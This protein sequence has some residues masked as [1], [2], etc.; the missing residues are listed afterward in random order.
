MQ[1]QYSQMLSGR[2]VQQPSMSGPSALT[3]GGDRGVRM[4]SGGST[5]GM[6]CG[7]NNGMPIS[8]PGFQGIGSPGMLNVVTSGTM[9]PVS[10]VGMS[11]PVN[12]HSNAVSGQ[13]NSLL[14]P[15]DHLQVQRVSYLVI[16]FINQA[17]HFLISCCG[18]AAGA[19][20][21]WNP[22]SVFMK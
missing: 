2:N 20:H 6:M 17:S 16:S 11:S 8:R 15:R 19:S 7:V 4:L 12:M 1:Q 5:M 10:G 3:M 18:L 22:S 9:L 13:G 14:R 21:C